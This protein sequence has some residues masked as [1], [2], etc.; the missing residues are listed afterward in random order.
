MQDE[1]PAEALLPDTK[2]LLQVCLNDSGG[3]PGPGDLVEERTEFLH[4]QNPPSPSRYPSASPLLH[5]R[6][7]L[8]AGATGGHSSQC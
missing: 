3:P 2:Q 7:P 5:P 8:Q 1:A 4:S 6:R